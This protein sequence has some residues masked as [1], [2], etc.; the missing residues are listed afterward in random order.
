MLKVLH[1]ADLH[2]D[3]PFSSKS[4]E[5]SAL[6]RRQLREAFISLTDYIKKEKI[7]IALFAGDIFDS[8]TVSPDTLS[9]V[10]TA[11][12]N[13][14]D[15]RFVISAGNHDPYS[16]NGIYGTFPFPSNTYIFSSSEMSYFDFPEINACVYGYSFTSV[17]MTEN[18]LIGFAPRSPERINL[19]CAH[20][21]IGNPLSIYCPVSENDIALSSFD[22]C[23][24]GHIHRSEGVKY[25]GRVPYSYS[26]CLS[27][28]DFGETG[29]K[30]ATVITFDSDKKP[31]FE[32]KVFSYYTY[33]R[34]TLDISEVNDFTLL[35]L[36]IKE[37]IKEFKHNSFLRIELTGQIPLG[38]N[39]DCDG[40][41]QAFK[42]DIFYLEILDS[43]T[44]KINASEL[45]NDPTL[46]GE[47]YREM[48]H[49]LENGTA[50]ER[51]TA[52]LA[53]KMGISALRGIDLP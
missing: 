2:L 1:C 25:A 32:S 19:L 44:L 34:T 53:F 20:G 35:R 4:A 26:G 21:D 30:G 46:I 18:P 42:D 29:E 11:F 3:T 39:I 43:T 31:S 52:L 36:K 47:F 8:E 23:A 22:Y 12:E 17:T 51:K 27:G 5:H 9:L 10:K 28:R 38:L 48:K 15:C 45:E 6:A 7:D 14:P 13:A 33:E 50:E 24:F 49:S 41:G 40:L 37:C 16:K